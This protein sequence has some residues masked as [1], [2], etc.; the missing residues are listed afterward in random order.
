MVRKGQIAQ[1]ILKK[2]LQDK[3]VCKSVKSRK[4]VENVSN[5]KIYMSVQERDV[6][7]FQVQGKWR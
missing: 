6:C 1:K 7:V 3:C 4:G 2:I 5:I